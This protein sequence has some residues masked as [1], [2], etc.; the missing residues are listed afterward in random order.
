MIM[1]LGG[2]MLSENAQDDSN[3]VTNDVGLSSEEIAKKLQ[4]LEE[5]QEKLQKLS[6]LENDLMLI[7]SELA[8]QPKLDERPPGY[9]IEEST[10]NVEPDE[11]FSSAT[12]SNQA[13]IP[14]IPK[15]KV[16][17]QS[18]SRS[19]IV[20]DNQS[21]T[22]NVDSNYS[23][24]SEPNT[25]AQVGFP[26]HS[27][28]TVVTQGPLPA[29]RFV[30]WLGFFV[31]EEAAIAGSRRLQNKIDFSAMGLNMQVVDNANKRGQYYG[32]VLTP[33]RTQRQASSFCQ[34][35]ST[36]G[37]FCKVQMNPRIRG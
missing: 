14:L 26:S 3:L 9:Q 27:T 15:P 23:D 25:P 8:K 17:K 12:N 11:F 7:L 19:E 10:V 5:S 36:Y 4:E 24:A 1:F 29:S 34:A 35:L 2:C 33:F 18:D 20:A 16:N 21:S 28:T 13:L 30:I 37:Q 6:E 31:S 22:E 32:L